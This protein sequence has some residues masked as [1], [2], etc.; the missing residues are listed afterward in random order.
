MT[1]RNEALDKTATNFA[2]KGLSKSILDIIESQNKANEILKSVDLGQVDKIA[3]LIAFPSEQMKDAMRSI[4]IANQFEGSS[5]LRSLGAI[6]SVKNSMEKALRPIIDVQNMVPKYDFLK[7][8]NAKSFP[9]E[10]VP[11]EIDTSWFF[12]HNQTMAEDKNRERDAYQA[13]IE[14]REIQVELVK[15]LVDISKTQEK[16]A[17][18]I[19]MQLEE[20]RQNSIDAKKENKKLYRTSLILG[21]IASVGTFIGAIQYIENKNDQKNEI[22]LKKIDKLQESIEPIK[23]DAKSAKILNIQKLKINKIK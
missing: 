4:N 20:Q 17:S 8:Y 2:E 16:Q 5:I 23:T 13:M 3:K 15:V 1:S 21:I 14:T 19:K 11:L 12:E 18:L 10:N 9:V 22:L 7:D 6:D